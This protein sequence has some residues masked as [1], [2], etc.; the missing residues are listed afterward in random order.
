MRWITA[1]SKE[2]AWLYGMAGALMIGGPVWR[3]MYLFYYPLRPEM[4]GLPLV[5][6]IIGAL[7]AVSSRLVGGLVGTL[8][9]GALLFVFADL[10]FDLQRYTYTAAILATCVLVA[11]L[12]VRHRAAITAMALG[13]FYLSSLVRPAAPLRITAGAPVP[14]SGPVLVHIILDEQWGIGGLR[15]DGD[16]ATADFLT[17]F[18]LDRGFEVFEGAY[19][20]Y[21]YTE[22]SVPIAFS[23]GQAPGFNP[24]K[25]ILP[26]GPY[27]K[28]LRR[29]PYLER[30][31]ELGY[32]LRVYQSTFLDFCSGVDVPVADCD[33][34]SSNSIAN[35]GFLGGSWITR[36]LWAARYFLSTRSHVYAKLTPETTTWRRSGAHGG[37]AEMQR[38]ASVLAAGRPTSTAYLVHVLLPHRPI[39]LDAECRVLTDASKYADYE[40][41]SDSLWRAAVFAYDG[42]VRCTHRMLGQVID[43]V[44]S[45]AGR[46]N[47][48]VIVHGDHGSRMRPRNLDR[49]ALDAYSLTELNSIFSTLLAVRRPGVAAAL[50]Q[51]PV[52][53][54]DAIWE[55]ARSGFADSLSRRWQHEV[56]SRPD[57]LGKES[58]R[59]LTTREMLWVRREN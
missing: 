45:T 35:I 6:G 2:P 4:L 42:Q 58:V 24:D 36:G 1:R 47:S 29:T 14:S 16:S 18:Y 38:L 23:L 7:G 28:S 15:A 50:H 30:L 32:D 26:G 25:P 5:G 9:F 37:I 52:P 8:V 20:R 40:Y 11:A 3:E 22:Q 33:V 12:L 17:A 57:S 51:Y 44:D 43:A 59:P 19:S 55:F 13:A 53:V 48:I 39:Q 27:W 21:E 49:E 31:R 34:Q 56:R 10:Q 46:D 54:Q 41:R